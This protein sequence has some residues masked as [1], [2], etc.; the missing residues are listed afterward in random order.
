MRL[1]AYTLML[2]TLGLHLLPLQPDL[3]APTT[4]QSL[5]EK[6]IFFPSFPSSLERL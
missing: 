5:R 1:T 6:E 4:T 3:R 2:P